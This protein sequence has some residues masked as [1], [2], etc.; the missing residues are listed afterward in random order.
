MV[1]Y[2][3]NGGSTIGFHGCCWQNALGDLARLV[4]PVYGNSTVVGQRKSG[5][6]VNEY[7]RDALLAGIGDSLP[8]N[9][10]LVGQFFAA[11]KDSDKNLVEP[12]PPGGE[13]TVLYRDRSTGTPLVIAYQGDG[14]GRSMAFSGFFVRN[15]PATG[16]HYEKLLSQPEFSTLLLDC[17]RW[18]SEG[19][20]RFNRYLETYSVV[21]EERI[22][23]REGLVSRAE[24]RES[25]RRSQR[26]LLL[27]AFWALGVVAIAGLSYRAFVR[28]GP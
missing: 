27:A 20:S 16:N 3:R 22:A 10:D 14:G 18:V 12:I 8:E 13:K 7:S 1:A 26:T 6:S 11:P 4:F 5:L 25:S 9:F 17:Y 23:E 24:E 2:F 28:K 19:N 21:I 15:N